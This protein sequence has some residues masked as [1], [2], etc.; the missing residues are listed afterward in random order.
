VN[1]CDNHMQCRQLKK[2][3]S[4]AVSAPLAPQTYCLQ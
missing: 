4:L 3:L 1:Y 2:D